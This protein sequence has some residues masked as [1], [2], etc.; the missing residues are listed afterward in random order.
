MWWMDAAG[1]LNERYDSVEDL[2]RVRNVASLQLAG[3]ADRRMLD[4]NALSDI[5]V[6]IAGR[7]MGFDGSKAQF[8]GSLRNLCALADLKMNRLLDAIDTWAGSQPLASEIAPAHRFEPTRVEATPP[9]SLNLARGDIKTIIWATG[10]QPDYAWLELPVVDGKGRLRHDG[11]IVAQPGVYAMGLPFMRR[12][13]STLIDG[14][15]DDARELSAHLH[16][17]LRGQDQRALMRAETLTC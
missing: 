14:A 5:G 11:G 17:Y 4:L 2:T 16:A 9:L 7:L 3:Y 15:A 8:S 1:V 13:K 10:F 6:T 12:R